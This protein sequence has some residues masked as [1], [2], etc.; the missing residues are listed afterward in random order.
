MGLHRRHLG[1]EVLRYK[2][3][4]E[5]SCA[6]ANEDEIEAPVEEILET[7]LIEGNEHEPYAFDL[8]RGDELVFSV[9]ANDYLDAV[10]CDES[11]FDDWVES[12]LAEEH[13][14]PSGYWFRTRIIE[15]NN[16]TFMAPKAG[17][18]I[19]LLWR[20]TVF[21][22][23]ALSSLRRISQDHCVILPKLQKP[24]V[25][26]NPSSASRLMKASLS[27]LHSPKSL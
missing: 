17:R 4:W 1:G 25:F 23:V 27:S 15:G 18:Y 24:L 22:P 3:L 14:L 26:Q 9:E 21:Q 6:E 13:S 16:C 20:T 11:D 5:K 2:R 10:I 7:K 12:D 19:L 8:E